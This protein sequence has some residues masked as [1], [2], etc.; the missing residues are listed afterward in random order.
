V[1]RWIPTT[2][3]DR[4]ICVITGAFVGL[5][6]LVRLLLPGPVGLAD[7]GDAHQLMCQVGVR[8]DLPWNGST[9]AYLT[10]GWNAYR[11]TGDGCGAAGTGETY[12]STQLTLLRA[13]KV[14]S[15]VFGPDHALDLRAL[16]VVCSAALGVLAGLITYL[17]PGRRRWR[18]VAVGALVVVVLDCGVAG[19]FTS[20]YAEP[21]ALLG[22]LAVA[23][24]ALAVLRHRQASARSLVALASAGAFTLLAKTDLVGLLPLVVAALVWRP[25]VSPTASRRARRSPLAARR[26]GIGL[27]VGLTLLTSW[28]VASQPTRLGDVDRHHQVFDTILPLG[29]QPSHDLAWFGLDPSSANDADRSQGGDP[30]VVDTP[31]DREV[32]PTV[33]WGRIWTFYLVHPERLAEL[34]TKGMDAAATYRLGS[35]LSSY[36]ADSGAPAHRYERRLALMAPFYGLMGW[37]PPLL[38]LLLLAVVALAVRLVRRPGEALAQAPAL[39]AAGLALGALA[40]FWT[41]LLTHGLVETTRHL[42]V[43]DVLLT[44]SVPL[45]AV[46]Y[47]ASRRSASATVAQ[48]E[49]AV[50]EP[51]RVVVD[52]PGAF[53]DELMT[54]FLAGGGDRNEPGPRFPWWS[55]GGRRSEG[56]RAAHLDGPAGPLSSPRPPHAPAPP[57]PLPPAPSPV[58]VAEPVAEPVPAPVQVIDW[59]LSASDD[60][61]LVALR[62]RTSAAT[63]PTPPT[64][65]HEPGD[66]R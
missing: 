38:P 24:T 26:L 60:D 25:A 45:L 31:A 48:V 64:T 13:A 20:G 50:R 66:R 9:S 41:A 6:A 62:R 8:A 4:R 28:Y 42:L 47:V 29:G 54:R 14:I 27:A 39:V 46:A 35:Y 49:R 51:V 43:S 59:L 23:I 61:F 15:P 19:F 58:P 57:A 65:I 63:D 40:T 53:D 17:L 2:W 44:W 22:V 3:S 12:H 30:A 33:G 5:V 18:V 1:S 56:P 52:E 34:G 11:W 55:R 37:L 32:H 36:P 10:L 7:Q 21:A 16:A